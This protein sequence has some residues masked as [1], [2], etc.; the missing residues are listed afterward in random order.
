MGRMLL[1][2][3]RAGTILPCSK[4]QQELTV[5]TSQHSMFLTPPLL[6]NLLQNTQDQGKIPTLLYLTMEETLHCHVKVLHQISR[7]SGLLPIEP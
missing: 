5:T 6:Q 1:M 3:A 2:E 7:G 4:T